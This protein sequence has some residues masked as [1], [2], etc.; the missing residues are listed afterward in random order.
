MPDETIWDAIV[1]IDNTE[2]VQKE[3]TELQ[4]IA[5][6]LWDELCLDEYK[7]TSWEYSFI[8]DM[9]IISKTNLTPKQKGN[10]YRLEEKYL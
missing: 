10:L 6:R 4:R 3:V 2:Q 5:N 7:F 8:H 9:Y 1:E